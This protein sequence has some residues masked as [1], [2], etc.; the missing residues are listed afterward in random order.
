[1]ESQ[2][3]LKLNPNLA[4]AHGNAGEALLHFRQYSRGEAEF[5]EAIRLDSK[6]PEFHYD[7]ARALMHQGR[8]AEAREEAQ[9]A[10]SAE[11]GNTKYRDMMK[12]LKMLR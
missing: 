7:L 10:L 5:R 4:G 8:G 9:R 2:G 12:S 1:M 6:T 3:A 11:P